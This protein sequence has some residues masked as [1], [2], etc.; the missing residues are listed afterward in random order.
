MADD[1]P[2]L[3]ELIRLIGADVEEAGVRDRLATITVST[4]PPIVA[5]IG[6]SVVGLAGLHVMPTL[7]RERPVGRIN[8]L[9]VAEQL[10]GRGIG[11]ML[12]VAAEDKLRCL[13]CEILEITSNDRLQAAHAFYRHMGYDRTSARFAK[14]L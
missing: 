13:G 7:H 6:G 11:K 14:N 12:V 4:I 5:T 3:V 8:A 2:A 1:V 10:R 9:V